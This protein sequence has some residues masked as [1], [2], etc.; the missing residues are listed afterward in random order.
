M[1]TAYARLYA[2]PAGLRV[3]H[4]DLH[5]E[6]I[7]I[8]RR[9]LHPLDFEDTAWG[10]PVQDIAMALQDLWLEVGAGAYEPLL[11]AFRRGY[12]SL[13]SPWPEQY[14]GQI[15]TF[16]AGRMLWVANYVARFERPHLAGFI[17]QVAQRVR[18]ISHSES[19]AMISAVHCTAEIIASVVY[20]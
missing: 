7:K 18:E 1:D 14:P 11:A 12:E 17:E 15:D 4:H 13:S 5:H 19:L 9:R 10:Y 6:N 16:R 20:S 8:Y 2:D 3:I